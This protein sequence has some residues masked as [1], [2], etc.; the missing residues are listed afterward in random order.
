[1]FDTYEDALEWIHTRRGVTPKP[2]IR[3][4]EWMMEKLD[5][6]EQK[7]K[8]IHV[9]GTNGKGSTV[10]YLTSLFQAAGKTVGGFTSPHIMSFNERISINGVPISDE[11]VLSLVNQIVPLYEETSHTE[12]G[13]LTE[14]EVVT[15]MMFLYFSSIKPDVVLIEVGL[16]GLF[17]STNVVHPEVSVITTIGLDHLKILGNTIEEIALQK[18]GIIK[19]KVPLILGNIQQPARDVLLKN[20]K[21]KQ[22]EVELFGRDFSIEHSHSGEDF[23]EYFDYRSDKEYFVE[24]EIKLMGQHQIENAVTALRAFQTYC[25]LT[26]IP[27]TEALIR[28]GFIH[29]FW[30][31]RLEIISQDPFII[32]DGAHNEPAMEVLLTALKDHFPDRRIKVLYASITT[33]ELEKIGPWLERI[34]QSEIHLTTFDFPKAA[35]VEELDSRLQVKN[36]FKHAHWQIA[37][38]HLKDNLEENEMILVTGSLYF[39][40]D[41]RRYL[42]DS[43]MK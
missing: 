21:E 11:E 30:P 17:D 32:L 4:M 24:L 42:L 8:S 43:E 1:M 5:H 31:V 37:L 18:A 22:V 7:F 10:A 9:A 39:L 2:G 40:S 33:K 26:H 16:G 41:V 28:K 13:R 27:Y 35:T 29:A 20:A 6:P 36:A 23:H 3:R 12:L 19:D 25:S 38:N 14:F 34:P 15:S